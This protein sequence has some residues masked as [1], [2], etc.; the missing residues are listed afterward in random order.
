[1][2]FRVMSVLR[3]EFGLRVP[4]EVA[5]MGCGERRPGPRGWAQAASLPL[6]G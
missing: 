5:A 6:H 2:A 4:E 1:M 3:Q